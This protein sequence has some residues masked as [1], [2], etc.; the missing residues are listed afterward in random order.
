MS[1]NDKIYRIVSIIGLLLHIFVFVF[2]LIVG[3]C[4]FMKI[5]IFTNVLLDILVKIYAYINRI[6]YWQLCLYPVCQRYWL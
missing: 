2:V 4:H 3:F 5:I 1:K 6:L